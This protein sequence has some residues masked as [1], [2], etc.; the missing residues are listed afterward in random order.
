MIKRT[1][2]RQGAAHYSVPCVSDRDD[3][4]YET[5][6]VPDADNWQDTDHR[7]HTWTYGAERTLRDSRDA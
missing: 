4:D 2:P 5:E 7:H 1:T 3:D 6:Y